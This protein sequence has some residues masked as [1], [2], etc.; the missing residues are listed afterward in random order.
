VTP[1]SSPSLLNGEKA[2]TLAAFLF[3]RPHR[4][5]LQ[6]QTQQSNNLGVKVLPDAEAV[7]RA[8]ADLIISELR[9]KPNLVLCTATGASPTRAYELLAEEF[10]RS[11]QLFKQL[12]ILKLDEWGG[13]AMDDPGS[14]EAYLRRYVLGPLAISSDRYIGFQSEPKNPDQEAARIREWVAANGPIDICV[15]GLGTNGHLAMNEPAETLQPFAHVAKLAQ[16]TLGHGMLAASKRKPAYGL[17]LGLSEI[18]HSKR[19]LL[20]VSGSG[21][22]QQLARLRQ[23]QISTQFPASLLWLHPNVSCFCDQQAA[24]A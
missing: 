20:L 1:L 12:R 7:G 9:A 18:F 23:Q 21:K 24:P 4:Q 17:T 10:R 6:M 14:C 16:T 5:C 22:T 15:L 11:P 2:R 19:I 3:A 8:G 13:L